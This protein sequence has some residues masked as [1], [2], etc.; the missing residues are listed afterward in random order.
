M[1]KSSNQQHFYILTIKNNGIFKLVTR[2]RNGMIYTYL[3]TEGQIIK[4]I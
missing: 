2:A 3:L 4:T 1:F